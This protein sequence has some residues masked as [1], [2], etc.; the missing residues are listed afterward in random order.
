[1]VC[2]GR[3]LAL[4][5]RYHTHKSWRRPSR[6]FACHALTPIPVGIPNMGEASLEYAHTP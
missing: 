4:R 3:T 5:L 6:L 2:Q 1:M